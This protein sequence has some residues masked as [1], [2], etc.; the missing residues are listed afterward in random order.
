MLLVIDR[1]IFQGKCEVRLNLDRVDD[2]TRFNSPNIC[3]CRILVKTH[4]SA[5]GA[6]TTFDQGA[7]IYVGLLNLDGALQIS[8]VETA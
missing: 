5:Q 2:M 8:M 1:E 3:L 4:R 7:A 6:I